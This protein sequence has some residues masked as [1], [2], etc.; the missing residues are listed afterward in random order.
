MPGELHPL[1]SYLAIHAETDKHVGGPGLDFPWQARYLAEMAAAAVGARGG[2]APPHACA[3]D[4]GFSPV[5]PLHLGPGVCDGIVEAARLGMAVQIL[6]NPVAGTT[7]P[8][9]VAA[10]LA[11][12]DAE[13][14]AGVVLAQ[15]AERRAP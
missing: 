14:L 11:Q 10:A 8:A 9:T 5:S 1:Y 13:V 3:I 7:A 15:A 4:M 12:Q 6:T 2:P